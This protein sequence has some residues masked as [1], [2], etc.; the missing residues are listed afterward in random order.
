DRSIIDYR[1]RQS[2]EMAATLKV[3]V[4]I[5]PDF[6][7][8]PPHSSD[9]AGSSSSSSTSSASSTTASPSS[10]TSSKTHHPVADHSDHLDVSTP[11]PSASSLSSPSSLTTISTGG[12]PLLGP[13]YDQHGHKIKRP[14]NAFMVW[15]QMRRAEITAVSSKVHNSTISKALGV[16]W[17]EMSD[18]AKQ[19]YVQKA[20]ELRDEL[21]REHPHYVY[22]PRKR[23]VRAA[24]YSPRPAPLMHNTTASLPAGS[25]CGLLLPPSS[26]P[27]PSLS[28]LLMPLQQQQQQSTMI[29]Q[30][31]TAD[32]TATLSQT[33][34]P[35]FPPGLLQQLQQQLA[36]AAV[37]QPQQPAPA[38]PVGG[39]A[40]MLN[41]LL[42]AN[43]LNPIFAQMLTQLTSTSTP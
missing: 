30:E 10:S 33:Q 22:R 35:L 41:P 5:M 25:A 9:G 16:E 17:R 7:T 15:A 34:F 8:P 20:K 37:M 28:A 21:F 3:D 31:P 36:L 6:P 4:S 19:P 13:D 32:A 39:A 26:T 38:Q 40:A 27:P 12:C 14:M 18:E 24:P 23:K 43:L 1:S 11:P 2:T 29:K 42:L